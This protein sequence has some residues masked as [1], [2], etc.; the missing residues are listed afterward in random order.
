MNANKAAATL[1][2]VPTPVGRLDAVEVIPAAVLDVVAK[3][4]FLVAENAKSARLFLKGVATRQPLRLPLQQIEIAVLDAST[5]SDQLRRLLDPLLAGRDAGL[6]S[7]AGA[8]AVADPGAPLVALAHR[9]GIKVVPLVGPSAILLALMASGLNG[10]RFAF[11]GYLPVEPAERRSA[12][13]R[14]ERESRQAHQT[15]IM[16]ETPYRNDAML[17]TAIECL[18]EASMLCVA[19]NLTAPDEQ[20]ISQPVAQWRRGAPVALKGRPAIFLLLAAI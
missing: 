19:C 8:P 13:K 3:L 12:L 7:E 15:Q 20:I 14:L 9:L 17:A 5:Q 6:L 2:L 18:E 1:Y 11:H 4:D 16:I 10:Q